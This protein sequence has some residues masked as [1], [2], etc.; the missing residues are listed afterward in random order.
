MA[1]EKNRIA[2]TVQAEYSASVE[3]ERLLSVALDE[4]RATVVKLNDG[5]AHYNILKQEVDS[6]KQLYE[7]LL[8]RLK[9]AGKTTRHAQS[10][11]ALSFGWATLS[12]FSMKR[13]PHG[14]PFI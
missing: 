5:I 2:Q 14:M 11:S 9:E 7:G 8:T 12:I 13:R 10:A 4:Q 1:E 6:N 3:R